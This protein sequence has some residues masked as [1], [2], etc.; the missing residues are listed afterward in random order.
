MNTI[1]F[2]LYV[3]SKEQ[4]K[5][6]TETD[7]QMQRRDWWLLVVAEEGE[8][9]WRGEKGEEIQKYK[10]SFQNGHGMESTAQGI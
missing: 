1:W 9:W 7:S 2:H 10:L 6:T 3:E 4:N 8:C 5:L